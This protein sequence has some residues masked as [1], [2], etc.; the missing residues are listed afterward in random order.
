M[1]TR[2]DVEKYTILI[3]GPLA[4]GIVQFSLIALISWSCGEEPFVR[5]WALGIE[6]ISGVVL[7]CVGLWVSF[8][9]ILH[10]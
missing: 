6:T 7:F 3:L 2:N 9:V 8:E 5:G 10:D 4:M 1:I